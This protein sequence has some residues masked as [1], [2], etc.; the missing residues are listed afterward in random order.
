MIDGLT[1]YDCW[2]QG[3]EMATEFQLAISNCPGYGLWRLPGR[4]VRR[5]Y[6]VS[7]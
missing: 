3:A 1:W 2:R 4:A 6:E 7:R 5:R